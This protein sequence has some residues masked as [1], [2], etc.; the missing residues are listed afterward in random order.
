MTILVRSLVSLI[1]LGAL[2]VFAFWFWVVPA[3]P[4]AVAEHFLAEVRERDWESAFSETSER[5]QSSH[6]ASEF[7]QNVAAIPR[8]LDHTKVRFGSASVGQNAAVLDGSLLAAG[9]EVPLAVE[10]LHTERRWRVDYLV[11]QGVPL[12]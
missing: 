1:T 3:Q 8:L 7:E 5:Y 11:V 10:L 6:S 9:Q 4:I 12:E 2:G